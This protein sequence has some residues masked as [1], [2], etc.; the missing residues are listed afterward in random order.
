VKGLRTIK[1]A[2][3]EESLKLGPLTQILSF[4][5]EIPNIITPSDFGK[6][7][8]CKAI[9]ETLLIEPAKRRLPV[10]EPET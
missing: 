5:S 4:L 7:I 10:P 2:N 6:K 3:F 9:F 8:Y 1:A